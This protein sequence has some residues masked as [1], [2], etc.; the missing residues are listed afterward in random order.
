VTA[1]RVIAALALAGAGLSTGWVGGLVG[2]AGL[3][4]LRRSATAQVVARGAAWALIIPTIAAALLSLQFG[5]MPPLRVLSPC[6]LPLVALVVS[7]PLLDDDVARATFAPLALRRWFLAAATMAVAGGLALGELA[8]ALSHFT[9]GGARLIGVFAFALALSGVGL[10]RMRTWGVV[11]A[12]LSALTGLSLAAG[13][14]WF[15][16]PMVFAALPGAMMVG[17]ILEAR[18]RVTHTPQTTLEPVRVRVAPTRDEALEEELVA[19]SEEPCAVPAVS[20]LR[21]Q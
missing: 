9:H 12:V 16:W 20:F 6:V 7:R 13:T 18:R 2:V 19:T 8:G 10:V 4:F 3:L 14:G 21:G 17:G 11:L 5:F 15:L 1:R